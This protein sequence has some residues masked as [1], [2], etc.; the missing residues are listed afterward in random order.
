MARLP[1]F[2]WSALHAPDPLLRWL[3]LDGYGFHQAYFRTQRYVHEQYREARF[4]FPP[5]RAAAYA[6]R[7]VDQGIGRA[8]WFVGGTDVDRVVR[9]VE[10][11]P[12]QR[13]SDLY[14]GVGLAATYAG[15]ADGNELAELVRRAGRYGP[16]LAQGSAFAAAA[17]SR[18]GLIV[19][20]NDLATRVL[21]GLSTAEA[22]AV[23]DRTRPARGT[24]GHL[25]AY[26]R[27]RQSIRR[28]FVAAY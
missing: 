6:D 2:R 24:K 23:C 25:P 20:H 4:P 1:R 18:A 7:A 15:G 16:D 19:A 28:E 9:L 26:E 13:H 17:R 5:G 21:C 12:E 10:A 11:F 3:V 14:G 27:W 8:L 22:A